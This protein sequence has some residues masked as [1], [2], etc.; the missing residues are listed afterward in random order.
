MKKVDIIKLRL[1][2]VSADE[3]KQLMELETLAEDADQEDEELTPPPAEEEKE[4]EKERKKNDTAKN[5]WLI[6]LG[7]FA[8]PVAFPVAIAIVAVLFSIFA[9]TRRSTGN[10]EKIPFP[11]FFIYPP[12][13]INA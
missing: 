9:V 8:A 1:K 10:S 4:E 7:I 2:G 3:I 13:T 12:R 11:T 5:V 6:I